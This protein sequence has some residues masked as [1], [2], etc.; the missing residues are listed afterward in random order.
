MDDRWHAI[1]LQHFTRHS[2]VWNGGQTERET[3]E[4]MKTNADKFEKAESEVKEQHAKAK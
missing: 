3:D 2:A 4:W 1:M